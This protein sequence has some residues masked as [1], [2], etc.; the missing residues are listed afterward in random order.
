MEEVARLRVASD[1]AREDAIVDGRD[2]VFEHLVQLNRGPAKGRS[3]VHAVHRLVNMNYQLS[4]KVW[5]QSWT[6]SVR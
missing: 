5:Q 6:H 2:I 1:C 3:V 4:G